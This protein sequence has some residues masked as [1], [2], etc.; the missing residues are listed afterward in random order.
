MKFRPLTTH[1]A[2]VIVQLLLV[3][4]PLATLMTPGGD[5]R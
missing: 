2:H 1:K 5:E 4:V 3:I